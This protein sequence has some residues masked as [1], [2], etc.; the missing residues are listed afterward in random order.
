MA[1][2]DTAVRYAFDR[3]H[4]A[5]TAG[6]CLIGIDEVGRGPLAGPVVTAAVCLDGA[7]EIDGINDSKKVAPKK[8]DQ[9]YDQIIARA[10]GFCV[11]QASVEEIEKINILQAT[12]RAMQRAI[13]GL[14]VEWT[15][16]MV[17]G[18]QRV[19][20]VL[21]SRQKTVVGGDGL[22]ASIAAASIIAKVTRDRLMTEYHRQYPVYGF[23]RHKGYGTADHIA[24][25]K[26]FGLSPIHRV[27]FCSA[28][29]QPQLTLTGL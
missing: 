3:T 2:S 9:L 29:T 21:P 28:F 5:G 25:I 19:P 1:R 16:M 22:S 27:S 7:D 12:L 26:K 10:R 11:G 4:G 18:N 8:R 14:T 20:T 15:L 13:D 6:C 17:D 24:A 23:D